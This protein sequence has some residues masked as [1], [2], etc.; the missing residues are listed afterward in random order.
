MIEGEGRGDILSLILIFFV[1][2]YIGRIL[3]GCSIE[4]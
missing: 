1:I 4:W 2:D 3:F